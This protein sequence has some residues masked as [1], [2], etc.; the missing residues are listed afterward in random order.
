MAPGD[1]RWL[2]ALTGPRVHQANAYQYRLLEIDRELAMRSRA[3]IERALQG[4]NAL[5]RE[6]LSGRLAAEGIDGVGLRRG[7]LLIDAE[8]E[9]VICS[10]PR[11]GKRQTYALVEERL[12]PAPART[13]EEG[14]AE[15]ARRYVEGHGP[16]QV[17]DLS[18]WSGLT[19]AD[20]RR[21]L[22]SATPPLVRGTIDGRTFWAS[23]DEPAAS[24]DAARAVR[25]LPNYDELL[26]AFRDRNDHIDPLLPPPAR[27][28]EVVLAHVLTRGGLVVGGYRRR[29]E[30]PS[31]RLE[32]DLLVPLDE[33]EHAAVRREVQRFETFLGRTVEAAGLD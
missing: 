5:T 16:A 31:R 21:A 28:A 18:W 4:G 6:E 10:G 12:P 30:R 25:L 14:L 13:R 17:V 32:V 24:D 9:G 23:P 29:E 20:A 8:L 1:L 33:D 22:E 27:V 19:V 11:R 26:I 15:L 3:I 2:L 7:Y